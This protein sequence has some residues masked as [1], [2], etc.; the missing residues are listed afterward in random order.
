MLDCDGGNTV[1]LTK[2]LCFQRKN[3]ALEEKVTQKYCHAGYISCFC[4][5]FDILRHLETTDLSLFLVGDQSAV[6]KH[7]QHNN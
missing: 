1:S 5:S 4:S 6:I 7:K 3:R 2:C